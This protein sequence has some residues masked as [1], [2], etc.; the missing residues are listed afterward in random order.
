MAI[1]W[2][3]NG[4]SAMNGVKFLL[5][6]NYIPGLVKGQFEVVTDIKQRGAGADWRLYGYSSISWMD[7]WGVPA[8][9]REEEKVIA[10]LLGMLRYFPITSDIE[11]AIIGLR[12]HCK[13]KLPDAIILATAHIHGFELPTLD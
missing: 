4:R 5:D 7:F 13:P 12:R 10:A 3:G 6:T 11:A 8:I 9:T 2:S 1:W